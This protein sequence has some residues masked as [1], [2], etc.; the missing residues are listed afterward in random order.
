MHSLSF[1]Q[2]LGV[3]LEISSFHPRVEKRIQKLMEIEALM[4]DLQLSK[5]GFSNMIMIIQDKQ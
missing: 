5:L 1:L 4:G 3:Q 2:C